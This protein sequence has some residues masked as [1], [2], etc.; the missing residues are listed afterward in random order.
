MQNK[1]KF[2]IFSSALLLIFVGVLFT[3]CEKSDIVSDQLVLEKSP[4][5]VQNNSSSSMQRVAADPSDWTLIVDYGSHGFKLFQ[6]GSDYV[7]KINLDAGAYI[8]IRCSTPA[9]SNSSLPSSP[10]FY[11]RSLQTFWDYRPTNTMSV[12]NGPFFW[13]DNT[14]GGTSAV[15]I[16]YPIK[17]QG[18]ILSTGSS[19]QEF[20]GNK[21]KIGIDTNTKEAW[22]ASYNNTSN[23][24]TIVANNLQSPT[25]F[26]GLHPVNVSKN[27]YALLNRTMI[28]IKDQNG[29]GKNE[30]IYILTANFSMQ[31]M[32]LNILK[33]FGCSDSNII[34]FDGSGSS[35]MICGAYSFLSSDA[36]NVP[37]VLDAIF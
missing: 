8:R 22:I 17:Y 23:D 14:P 21:L 11:R 12:T 25:A 28:G 9:Q 20:P 2:L 35:Q 16:S 24:P 19:N 13:Y 26:V 18:T 33:T 27:K 1:K 34:M 36:R 32:A 37:C 29:D 4:L 3:S 10:L 7:Q 31:S 6:K 30:V 5:L 15:A